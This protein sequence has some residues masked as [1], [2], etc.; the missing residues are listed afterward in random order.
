MDGMYEVLLGGQPVGKARVERQGLYYGISCRCKLSGEVIQK[1]EVTC[2]DHTES[3][4]VLV[5]DGVDFVL[6]TK[7][8]VKRLGDGEL[9]F[10]I[11]PRHSEI[12]GKFIPL[13]PEEPFAYLAKLENAFLEIRD[14]KMGILLKES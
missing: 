3:L 14:G 8:P 4:G 10:R 7:L 12:T 2:G 6:K 5:P 1:L 9:R 11:Q 13:S